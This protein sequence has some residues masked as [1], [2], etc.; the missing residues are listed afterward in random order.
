M[1]DPVR[2]EGERRGAGQTDEP[3]SVPTFTGMRHFGKAQSAV[4]IQ[5]RSDYFLLE[6]AGKKS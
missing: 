6:G 5:R 4:G 3:N 2:A 1:I